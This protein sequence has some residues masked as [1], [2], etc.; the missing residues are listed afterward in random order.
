MIQMQKF[1]DFMYEVLTDDIYDI[2]LNNLA[3]QFYD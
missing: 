3:F 2:Y 1:I